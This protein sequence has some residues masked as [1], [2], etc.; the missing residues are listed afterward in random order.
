MA[1]VDDYVTGKI[2]I[3]TNLVLS[4][5]KFVKVPIIGS[6]IGEELL[7]RIR[8]F[9]PKL[10]DMETAAK[11]IQESE[12]C[13]VGERVCR[14]I[15][16]NSE[17]T[18]SVFLDELAERMIKIE[19]ARYVTKEEAINTLKKKYYINPLILSKVSGKYMEICRTLPKVCVYWNME[20]RDLKCLNC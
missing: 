3:D 10:I 7:K 6:L 16:R 1:N 18:E 19:K 12:K 5:L 8:K 4:S 9:E 11:V 17:F 2:L 20:R 13:A 15:H 14:E